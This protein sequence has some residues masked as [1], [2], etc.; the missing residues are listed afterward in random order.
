ML[1]S[2][3]PVGASLQLKLAPADV[4]KEG[5]AFDLPIAIGILVASEQ[6]STPS[7][8]DF[9]LLGELS[10]DGSLRPVRGV[11]SMATDMDRQGVYGMIVPA[12]NARE[13][14]ISD[15]P[16]VYGVTSLAE[17]VEVLEGS[18]CIPPH[19]VVVSDLLQADGKSA[20]HFVEVRGQEH[21]KRALEVA[22]A[23]G[24]NILTLCASIPG[25]PVAIT[26]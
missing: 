15:G 21:A 4:R 16:V 26:P 10:L 5:S 24:H 2:S 14:A 13:A 17:A 20:L 25:K 3:G 11:L 7:L 8:Q 22:A 19:V 9:V 12:E 1:A 23:G 6:L 18:D